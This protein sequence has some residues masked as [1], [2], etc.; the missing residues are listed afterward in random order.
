MITLALRGRLC[1]VNSSSEAEV[2]ADPLAIRRTP[3]R[4]RLS[5]AL[6]RTYFELKTQLS[7]GWRNA[8]VQGVTLKGHIREKIYV[9]CIC[10]LPFWNTK[11]VTLTGKA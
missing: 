3:T 5:E 11:Q 1:T 2:N 8:R 10:K 7:K 9:S 6:E 4:R